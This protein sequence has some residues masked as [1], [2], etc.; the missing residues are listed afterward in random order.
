MDKKV[1]HIVKFKNVDDLIKKTRRFL[2]KHGYIIVKD[3]VSLT[4][5]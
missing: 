5:P 3:T 4:F 2:K 1:M